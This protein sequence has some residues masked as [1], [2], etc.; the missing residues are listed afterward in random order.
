MRKRQSLCHSVSLQQ[1]SAF[2]R[3]GLT[4]AFQ[5]EKSR[6][7]WNSHS[8]CSVHRNNA[9]TEGFQVSQGYVDEW[10]WYVA[11]AGH[12]ALHRTIVV[13]RALQRKSFQHPDNLTSRKSL[14]QLRWFRHLIRILLGIFLWR[15]SG[16]VQLV[17]DD[18]TDPEGEIKYLI[19]PEKPRDPPGG[20]KLC[21]GEEMSGLHF[22]NRCHRDPTWDKWQKMGRCIYRW[23][24]VG[25]P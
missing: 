16:Q 2:Y 8:C 3:A 4:V 12:K 20:E 9:T 21:W 17:G 23:E 5:P 22:L 19:W 14:D 1:I 25:K 11:S 7:T 6:H 18:V 10:R 13:K 15:C 24:N